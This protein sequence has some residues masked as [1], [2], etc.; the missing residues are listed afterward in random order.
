MVY[1]YILKLQSEKYYVGK[2]DWPEFRLEDHLT[3]KGSKWTQLYTPIKLLELIPDCDDFDEDKYVKICMAKYGIYNVRGGSYCQETL[4]LNQIMLLEKEIEASLDLCH[5]C[6]KKGHFVKD[7]QQLTKQT[8]NT[9]LKK[10]KQKTTNL[11]K[12]FTKLT[13]SDS[14]TKTYKCFK[15]G[16]AGHYADECRSKSNNTPDVKCFKCGKA[17]HYADECRS[18]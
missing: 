5:N 8:S 3:A 13:L 15:C 16:K 6:G 7:C 10:D 17:G 2:T 4:N 9:E 18:K 11:L 1:I 14:S 12:D